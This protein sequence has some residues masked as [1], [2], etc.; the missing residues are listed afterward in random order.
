[1]LVRPDSLVWSLENPIAVN[2]TL[3]GIHSFA[4][5]GYF[6][7]KG[8][9]ELAIVLHRLP[10]KWQWESLH[11]AGCYKPGIRFFIEG[12]FFPLG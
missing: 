8:D 12:F 1:M 10:E 6:T 11:G 2:C 3:Q 5:L 9:G 7:Q 4:S